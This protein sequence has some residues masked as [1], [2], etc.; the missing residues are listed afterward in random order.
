MTYYVEIREELVRIVTV[1][2]DSCENAVDQV[3]DRYKEQE[4]V[5]DSNDFE[6]VYIDCRRV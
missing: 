2:A 6:E 3:T 5:L 1:E 4:I